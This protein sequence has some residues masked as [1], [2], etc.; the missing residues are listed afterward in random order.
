M[1]GRKENFESEVKEKDE[2]EGKKKE[3]KEKLER[4]RE[5]EREWENSWGG[6]EWLERERGEWLLLK[7][8]TNAEK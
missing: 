5:R 2:W 6:R 1:F 7:W 4:E 8:E 3:F